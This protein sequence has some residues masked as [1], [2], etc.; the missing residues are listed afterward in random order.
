MYGDLVPNN[1]GN[2]WDVHS[3]EI[4]EGVELFIPTLGII[5]TDGANHNLIQGNTISGVVD[6]IGL[7]GSLTPIGEFPKSFENVVVANPGEVI[8]NLPDD[9]DPSF[10]NVIV[11]IEPVDE[12]GMA[13]WQDVLTNVGPRMGAG[14]E[15]FSNVFFTSLAAGLNMIDV[16]LKPI[17]PYTARSLAETIG[18]TAVIRYNTTQRRFEGYTAGSSGP[19]FVIPGGSGVIVNVTESKTVTF[20]G[21]AWTNDPSADMAPPATART[22]AWA[23]VLSGS[24]S[25]ADAINAGYTVKVTNQRTGET[26]SDTI[27]S[28][29]TFAAVA[30]DL[31]RRS[32][33]ASGDTLE[34]VVQDVYGRTV[35]GPYTWEITSDAIRQAHLHVILPFSEKIPQK[36]ALLQNYPNPFNPATALPVTVSIYNTDGQRVRTLALGNKDAG[37]YASKDRA[38]YWDGTDSF[39]EQVA[40]G[41]YFYTMQAGEFRATRKMVILK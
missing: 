27:S 22:S 5:A 38:V 14:M 15:G 2:Y 39:G 30:A 6:S 31:S 25:N 7:Y 40:S 34:A 12:A 29:G 17:A 23:F 3:N 33:V 36:V 37:V 18:A 20:V 8:E 4:T 41:V 10:G 35:S 26:V 21:A 13:L 11:G 19:G 28:D 1:P 24:L 16:P 32:V 9:P